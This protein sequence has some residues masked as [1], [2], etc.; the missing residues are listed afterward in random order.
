MLYADMKF[1]D[2]TAFI[3]YLDSKKYGRPCMTD[4]PPELGRAIITQMLNTPPVDDEKMKT[5]ANRLLAN[6]IR[7]EE[8][9]NKRNVC[10]SVK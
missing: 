3:S 5:E 6:I 4:L 1:D 9:A 2:N 10:I 8:E 7:A